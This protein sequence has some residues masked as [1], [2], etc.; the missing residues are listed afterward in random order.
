VIAKTKARYA[1]VVVV[2]TVQ[3]GSASGRMRVSFATVRVCGGRVDGE[4]RGRD[5][6]E[7]SQSHYTF[8]F[9]VL[10]SLFILRDMFSS[11]SS[12]FSLKN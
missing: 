3:S 1:C 8:L 6:V 10:F 4:V 7:G 12:F 11:F 2:A 9:S 5:D